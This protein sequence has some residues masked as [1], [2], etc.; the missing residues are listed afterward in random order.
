MVDVKQCTIIHHVDDTK[1]SHMNRLVV[2]NVLCLLEYNF[3]KLKIARVKYHEFLGMEI[4]CLDDEC[5]RMSMMPYLEKIVEE[6]DEIF[7]EA[8]NPARDDFLHV[9]NT[10]P[11]LDEKRRRLFTG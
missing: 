3:G 8:E 2:D 9:D 4:T 5:F 1:T 7:L 10:K 11:L 6:F